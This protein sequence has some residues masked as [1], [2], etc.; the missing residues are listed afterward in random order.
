MRKI[1]TNSLVIIIGFMITLHSCSNVKSNYYYQ[2]DFERIKKEFPVE[3]LSHFAKNVNGFYK[4]KSSFPITC[5]R[6]GR[7]GVF[8][9]TDHV[10]NSIDSLKRASIG[11]VGID[12]ECNLFVNRC[13]SLYLRKLLK[14]CDSL[15]YP[16]PD[17]LNIILNDPYVDNEI[18][19]KLN[20]KITLY[21]IDSKSGI[22]I[23]KD[24]LSKD[25]CMPNE[26][27]NGYSRGVAIDDTGSITIYW[28]EI[29]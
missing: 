11:F 20:N 14:D 6:K 18:K 19:N 17:I 2:S 10:G 8:L 22:S 3:L 23:N 15:S 7:C 27:R 25:N 29:W 21:I 24:Y 5:A 16:V 26:W 12:N 1:Y 4:F 13:D 28:L 9:I